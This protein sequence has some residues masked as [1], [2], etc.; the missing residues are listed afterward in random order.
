M[1]LGAARVVQCLYDRPFGLHRHKNTP[2]RAKTCDRRIARVIFVRN[3][4]VF[5]MNEHKRFQIPA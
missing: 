1:A 5:F 4:I 2:A 3:I